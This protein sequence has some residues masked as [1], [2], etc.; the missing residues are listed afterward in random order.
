MKIVFVRHGHPDYH[1][2]CLTELGH[3]QAE[4]AAQRLE[5]EGIEEIYSSTRGRALET[6]QYTAKRIGISTIVPCEFMREI[7]WG[8]RDGSEIYMKGL[9]WGVAKDMVKSGQ[10]LMA[11]DWTDREPFRNNFVGDTGRACADGFDALLESLGYRRE[12]EFYRVQ[13]KTE[14]TIAMFSHA[15]ASSAVLGRM[16]NLP[17]P[18]LCGSMEP[19]F[20][21][22]T[23]VCLSGEDGSLVTPRLEL[24]N[25]ARHIRGLS[26]DS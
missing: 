26:V 20:T 17:F 11:E 8:S 10:S 16:F 12:G 14:K 19:D 6:A 13:K 2:D 5:Q 21:S 22:V 9:P 4:A 15:G 24:F 23:I 7:K 25:D 18:F 1:N 3:L